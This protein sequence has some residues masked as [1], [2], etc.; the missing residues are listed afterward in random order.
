[1]VTLVEARSEREA[2]RK[3]DKD[4]RFSKCVRLD[5]SLVVAYSS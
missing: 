5:T 4:K 3:F 2:S 1:M